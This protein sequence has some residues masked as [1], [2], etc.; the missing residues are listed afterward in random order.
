[1]ARKISE[2]AGRTER[3]L[4]CSNN[5][6]Y[7]CLQQAKYLEAGTEL[8]RA[9]SVARTL[10]R[11]RSPE[12][13]QTQYLKGYLAVCLDSIDFAV[14]SLREAL[15]LAKDTDERDQ[16]VEANCRYV[17]ALA[18][19]RRG[20][21]D[22]ARACI[23][24]G[25][26][27]YRLHAERHPV[28]IA[29]AMT[30]LGDLERTAGDP[31]SAVA[32]ISEGLGILERQG[33]GNT[34]QAYSVRLRLGAAFS[35]CGNLPEAIACFDSA[36]ALARRLYGNDHVLTASAYASL[37]EAYCE[38]G[39]WS[40]AAGCL[41]LALSLSERH[42]GPR[43]SSL[44]RL[45]EIQAKNFLAQDSLPRARASI[46]R[47]IAIE[48]SAFS[49]PRASLGRM[50]E[51]LALIEQKSGDHRE[52]LASFDRASGIFS[53]LGVPAANQ[54]LTL[55]VE[56]GPSYVALGLVDSARDRLRAALSA[57]NRDG[58]SAGRQR[59]VACRTLGELCEV[60]NDTAQALA[61]YDQ[62]MIMAAGKFADH[63][64]GHVPFVRE[65]VEAGLAKARLLERC[66]GVFR[67]FGQRDLLLIGLCR[68]MI[69]VVEKA[70]LDLRGEDSKMTFSQHALPFCEI[71]I[72]ASLRRAKETRQE[73]YKDTAFAFA[74][75]GKARVLLES[76][77]R[78]DVLR[79]AGISGPVRLKERRLLNDIASMNILLQ[80]AEGGFESL[81]E[82]AMD[83]W[84]AK[85]LGA[86]QD[87]A[88]LED[89]LLSAVPGL[90]ALLETPEIPQLKAV[91]A[92]LSRN[93]CLVEYFH[94]R[95][96]VYAFVVRP[97][98]VDIVSLGTRDG[99]EQ[100]VADY[101]E[102][103]RTVKPA[104]YTLLA[105]ALHRK[106]FSPLEPFLHAADELVLVPEWSFSAIPFE[107]LLERPV[108]LSGTGEEID[109]SKL[110]YLVKHYSI[111]YAYSASFLVHG[112]QEKPGVPLVDGLIGFAPAFADPRS[113]QENRLTEPLAAAVTR[114]SRSAMSSL[115]LPALDN[116]GREVRSIAAIF[117][118]SGKTARVLLGGNATEGE[119]KAGSSAFAYVHVATH[120]ILDP[121]APKLSA[122][123]F[124]DP[125][126]T[127]AAEDGM[128]YGEEAYN[129]RLDAKLV[130]LSSCESGVGRA[131]RGEGLLALT[132]GFFYAGAG[133][134]LS[135]L[136][137]VPD[138]S[139]RELM[140]DF[141]GHVLRGMSLMRSVRSAKLSLI[142]SPLTAFP[143]EWA[144]FVLLG[145][146]QEIN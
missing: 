19:Q 55:T 101:V 78:N 85:R 16:I 143:R 54:L 27:L 33:M 61:C 116:S 126:D 111:S 29:C 56:S 2:A 15:R 83:H 109:F 20:A 97:D 81:D 80:R 145:M 69:G 23:D 144:G 86:L 114:E 40:R 53:H 102:S 24:R 103:I 18:Y 134:V 32:C 120:G 39:D 11:Q 65:Y 36:T 1:M 108:S 119:F 48:Q 128:L 13:V 38:L 91:Q 107:A 22:S 75:Y 10:I 133:N 90:R 130:T 124:A 35:E 51:T 57:L 60:K 28:Q 98:R 99:L 77:G 93:A 44:A 104:R 100:L 79:L 139:T 84:E 73:G 113:R 136:W 52:A 72:E 135:S 121:V 123:L 95:S 105:R 34:A 64:A 76:L 89:S 112:R 31:D 7:N 3:V 59:S 30:L 96:S 62:A 115:R 71:G 74:E 146:R 67:E 117:K 14:A 92:L 21:L 138:G 42:Y 46:A 41:D 118:R 47:A 132:R 6:A 50:F 88:H 106:L 87:L 129:L 142:A 8:R 9:D 49:R 17:L 125:G 43:H 94:G 131:M 58:P 12:I 68:E 25:L 137:K 70:R 5:I 141:Y 26:E 66:P 63:H 4:Y 37:G 122:L 110:P 140:V 45:W 82:T 127:L